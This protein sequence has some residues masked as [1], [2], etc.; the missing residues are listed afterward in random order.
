MKKFIVW[1]IV[2]VM[3]FSLMACSNGG[4]VQPSSDP[5]RIQQSASPTPTAEPAPSPDLG[6]TTATQVFENTEH[7]F[8]INY[9]AD[10]TETALEPAVFT[11]VAPIKDGFY[12]NVNIVIDPNATSLDSMTKEMLEQEYS[13]A[14]LDANVVDVFELQIAGQPCKMISTV[15]TQAEI[16]LFLEQY[17]VVYGGK[18]FIITNTCLDGD[19][20]NRQAFDDI[21]ASLRFLD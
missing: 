18:M 8:A 15:V 19:T 21:I 10:W 14:G 1:T 12:A 11:A 17:A 6:D 4:E 7:G 20:S 5:E 13:L 9:P 3:A 2:L 16:S